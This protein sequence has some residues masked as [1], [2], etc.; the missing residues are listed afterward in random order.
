MLVPAE[1]VGQLVPQRPLDLTG[2]QLAIVA[3]VPLQGVAVDHDPIL[4]AFGGDAVPEVLAV[5]V[6]LVAEI[7]DDDRDPLQHPL[8]FLREGIDRIGDEGFEA[9]WLGLIHCPH[10][11]QQPIGSMR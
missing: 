7:G 9:I 6:A 10:V 4:E 1:M 11:N 8:E 5:G 2:E 3:E